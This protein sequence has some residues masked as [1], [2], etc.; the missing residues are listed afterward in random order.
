MEKF[1]VL[2]VEDNEN[3]QILAQCLLEEMGFFVSIAHNGLDA[4]EQM[5]KS[6]FDIVL[7]DMQMPVMDGLTATQK[8][9]NELK[10]DVPILA[11][12]ANAMTEDKIKCKNAGMNDHLSKPIVFE[13]LT[14][15]LT[16]YLSASTTSE[17]QPPVQIAAQTIQTIQTPITLQPSFIAATSNVFSSETTSSNT[18]DSAILDTEGALARI[19]YKKQLYQ[20]ILKR[21]T[22]DY[23]VDR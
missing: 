2:L 11:M 17:T 16:E 10:I 12:T 9:R 22:E 7:M 6:T 19:S 18:L 14:Q 3:N 21:F 8:I 5:K 4:I 15:K 20:K 13:I 23:V 1:S